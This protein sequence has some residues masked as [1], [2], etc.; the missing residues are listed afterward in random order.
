M[1]TVP[2]QVT[3]VVW[4]SVQEHDDNATAVDKAMTICFDALESRT[5]KMNATTG[6][7]TAVI[8]MTTEIFS[9]S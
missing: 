2:V 6:G 9:P 5:H 8:S 7:L 4:V 3:A 1:K